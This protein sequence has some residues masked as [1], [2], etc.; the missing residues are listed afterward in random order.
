MLLSEIHNF[1]QNINKSHEGTD[2]HVILEPNYEEFT[3]KI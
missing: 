3:Y 1:V 2:K